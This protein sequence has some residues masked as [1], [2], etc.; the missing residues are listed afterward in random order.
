MSG[1]LSEPTD[2]HVRQNV[3]EPRPSQRADISDRP[4]AA[5]RQDRSRNN[6]LIVAFRSAKGRSFAERKT[7]LVSRTML[8]PPCGVAL[9]HPPAC[10][11][12]KSRQPLSSAPSPHGRR[13]FRRGRDCGERAGVRGQSGRRGPLTPTLS[14]AVTL[15]PGDH[16]DGGGEGAETGR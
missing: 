12:Q 13:D 9:S 16:T 11:R 15:F 14:P 7:T 5:G 10:G 3:G 4:R 6:C 2:S 1:S 8:S